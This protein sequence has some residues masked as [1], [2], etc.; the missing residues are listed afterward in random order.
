MV[1]ISLD[2]SSN[3]IQYFINNYDSTQES[4]KE[5]WDAYKEFDFA[6]H[7]GVKVHGRLKQTH[8]YLNAAYVMFLEYC[9]EIGCISNDEREALHQDFRELLTDLVLAQQARLDECKLNSTPAEK[10]DGLAYIRKFYADGKFKLAPSAKEFNDVAHD[11]VE[12]LD[13]LYVR[14]ERFRAIIKA[15]N[16]DPDEVADDLKAKGVLH[17]EA[18]ARTAQLVVGKKKRRCYAIKLSKLK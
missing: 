14:G 9:S 10:F 11:S 16:A 2:K 8:Y 1:E 5:W 17:H 3:F 6:E 18:N 15:A 12:H 7:Y 4:L 13:C